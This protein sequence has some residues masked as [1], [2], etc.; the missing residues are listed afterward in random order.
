MKSI[1]L[2][3]Q[4]MVALHTFNMDEVRK[5]D[6]YKAMVAESGGRAE[7]IDLVVEKVMADLRAKQSVMTPEEWKTLVNDIST[8]GSF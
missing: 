1:E 7:D 8:M 3:Q 2:N 6:G 5:T 4:F